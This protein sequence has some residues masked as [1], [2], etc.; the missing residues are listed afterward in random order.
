MNTH[1]VL[2]AALIVWAIFQFGLY[3]MALNDIVKLGVLV[4]QLH[5]HLNIDT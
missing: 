5:R 1:S 4:K 2:I 3:M